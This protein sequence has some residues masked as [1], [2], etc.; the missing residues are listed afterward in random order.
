[1]VTGLVAVVAIWA[2]AESS[3]LKA[4]PN[5]QIAAER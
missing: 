2:I 5:L 4:K 3:A 1:V